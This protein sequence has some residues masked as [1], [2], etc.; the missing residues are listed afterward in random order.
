[1]RRTGGL[2]PRVLA[3]ENLLAAHGKARLGKRQRPAV[4]R[5][6]L[7]LEHNLFDLQRELTERSYRPGAYRLFEIYDRKPRRI[8]AAPYRDRVVHHALMN[9]VEPV[10]DRTFIADSFACRVGKGVHAAVGRYQ[11][12]ARRY[13]YA[14]K[15]DVRRYFPSIDHAILKAKLRHRIKDP[16]V[17]WLFDTIIDSAPDAGLGQT[18]PSDD[19]VDL[20]QCRCGLPIGN[21]TSQFLG[22]LYLDDLDH[23]LKEVLRVPA[24]IR[25]VDDL[26]LLDDSKS[27]LWA[28]HDQI[29]SFLARERLR[30]HPHKVQ[31]LPTALGLDVLGYRV[32]P[33]YRRLR[34]DNGYRFRRHLRGLARGYAQG[35]I[36]GDAVKASVAA[37]IGHVR[38]ADSRGLRRAVLGSV[39]FRRIWPPPGA[40]G[41]VNMA[42]GPPVGR[43]PARGSRRRLEQQPQEPPLGLPQQE[44]RG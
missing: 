14:L 24:Y 30:L 41:S 35:E 9:L 26:I 31:V 19:L 44:H 43:C 23:H 42:A 15:L 18:F 2:W 22:N 38:H 40:Q 4:A 6:E 3:F 25:Y 5:F 12:W 21:L 7:D 13:A 36:S 39:V 16:G 29:D 11:A 37:W 32:F 8:A 33:E 34:R 1:M 27:R 17:L 20:M 28:W 10:L